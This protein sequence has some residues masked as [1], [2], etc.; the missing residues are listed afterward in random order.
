MTKKVKIRIDTLDG[1][2]ETDISKIPWSIIKTPEEIE[3]E[4][5]RDYPSEDK[6]SYLL[7]TCNFCLEK[8][9]LIHPV[10]GK[11]MNPSSDG[12]LIRV[13]ERNERIIPTCRTCLL[14]LSRRN[15]PFSMNLEGW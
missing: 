3:E 4:L 11:N 1:R 5:E 15:E 8:F 12:F 6:A 2:V 14:E 9:Y 13:S 7:Y 10:R